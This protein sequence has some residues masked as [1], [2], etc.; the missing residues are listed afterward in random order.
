M[1]SPMPVAKDDIM[2]RLASDVRERADGEKIVFV[3]GNFNILHPG[4]LRL[5]R[6]A[7]EQGRRLVVGV[8]ADGT[9]GVS[10]SQ[11]L[12]LQDVRAIGSVHDAIALSEPPERFIA[13]L[14]PECVVKGKEYM[15]LQNPE[16]PVVHSYGGAMLFSSGE[17]RFSSIDRLQSE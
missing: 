11:H 7:A 8:T 6:F 3:S 2:E 14:K 15:Q 12:R 16:L 4:H 13:R 17:V 1:S 5:F 9:D 10:V